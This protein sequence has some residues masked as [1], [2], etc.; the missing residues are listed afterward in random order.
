MGALL[1]HDDAI[2][3]AVQVRDFELLNRQ[4]HDN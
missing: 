3:E 4:R 1:T 2:L